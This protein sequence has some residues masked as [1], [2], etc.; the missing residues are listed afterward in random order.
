MCVGSGLLFHGWFFLFFGGFLVLGPIIFGLFDTR[1]W[2]KSKNT[3][4]PK[5]MHHRQKP[6]EVINANFATVSK[7]IIQVSTC[8]CDRNNKYP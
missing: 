7:T 2:I 6:T 5:L 3:L 8:D 4:R 1:Q